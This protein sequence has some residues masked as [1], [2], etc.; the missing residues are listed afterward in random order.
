MKKKQIFSFFYIGRFCKVLTN[1]VTNVTNETG[2][3]KR[4]KGPLTRFKSN[5][6]NK[7]NKLWQCDKYAA[8]MKKKKGLFKKDEKIPEKRICHKKKD[9]SL[10]SKGLWDIS[11]WQMWHCLSEVFLEIFKSLSCKDLYTCYICDKL[12]YKC[13]SFFFNNNLMILPDREADR[14]CNKG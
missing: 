7:N 12:L 1:S 6:T 14:A 3:L 5:R 2:L 9:N 4:E 10:R 13:H 11:P 8:I